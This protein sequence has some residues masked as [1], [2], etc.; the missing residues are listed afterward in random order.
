MSDKKDIDNAVP[1]NSV[2][3]KSKKISRI[4]KEDKKKLKARRKKAIKLKRSRQK[5]SFLRDWRK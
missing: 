5:K 2:G 4:K 3:I 1:D